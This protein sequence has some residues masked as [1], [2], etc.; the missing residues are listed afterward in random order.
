LFLAELTDD[1]LTE[2]HDITNACL[3]LGNDRFKDQIE[4]L[5][6]RSVRLGRRGR[7]KKG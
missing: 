3:V 6:G 2:V 4:A 5:L 1:I 7:P